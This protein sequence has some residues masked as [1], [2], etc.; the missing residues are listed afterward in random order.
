MFKAHPRLAPAL[1]FLLLVAFL[2]GGLA[3]RL[4][5]GPLE[6]GQQVLGFEPEG[7]AGPELACI[8]R[9]EVPRGATLSQALSREGVASEDLHQFLGRL[10]TLV[11]LRR[12]RPEDE[13][14][15]LSDRNGVL[16]RLEFQPDESSYVV[17]ERDSS[18]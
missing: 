2:A 18:G 17:V 15:L 10:S 13:Y 8:Q 16:T 12:V 9:G 7:P 1:A 6:D 3:I 11:D 5:K 14:R 4:V